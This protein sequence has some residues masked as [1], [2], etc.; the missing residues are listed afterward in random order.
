LEKD[1]SKQDLADLIAYIGR[2]GP[3]A[4]HFAGNEPGLVEAAADGAIVLPASNASIFGPS[5]VFEQHYGNLGYWSDVADQATWR[6]RVPKAGAYR[7]VLDYACVDGNAGNT[8]VIEAAGAAVSYKVGGT[9]TWDD[10]RDATIG[11]LQL[12]AGE[13]TV[14]ARPSGEPK[15]AI[16]DLRKIRLVKAD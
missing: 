16:V 13:I 3:Q 11:T 10:Y 8:L 6:V 5:L 14:V 4:K 15:S 7:V 2:L 1:L 12:P 9:G